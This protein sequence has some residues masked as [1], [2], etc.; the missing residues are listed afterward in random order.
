MAGHESTR[1]CACGSSVARSTY[2]PGAFSDNTGM[3]EI[4]PRMLEKEELFT[5]LE[6]GH[7]PSVCVVTPNRR[8]AR[9]LVAEFDLHQAGHGRLAWEAADILPLSSLVERMYE[10][11]CCAE[12]AVALPNLLS[13]DQERALWERHIRRSRHGRN[14]LAV[15]ETAVLASEAWSLAHAWLLMPAF[16]ADA[17]DEDSSAFSDWAER[18]VSQTKR[19]GQTER[20]RLP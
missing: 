18:Y 15:S 5:L 13:P 4:F 2:R 10:E 12:G 19:D 16:A 17:L 11:A 8:L 1:V 6:R 3:A 14:L 9:A 20:A 7:F